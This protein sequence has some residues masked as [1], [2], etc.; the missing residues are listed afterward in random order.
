M[1]F[2]FSIDAI[3]SFVAV[4]LKSPDKFSP[5]RLIF[6]DLEILTPPDLLIYDFAN[7]R[8]DEYEYLDDSTT[9]HSNKTGKISAKQRKTLEA[10]KDW[11]NNGGTLRTD[12]EF[13]TLTAAQ[14]QAFFAEYYKRKANKPTDFGGSKVIEQWEKGNK[15]DISQYLVLTKNP[16]APAVFRNWR[17][18]GKRHHGIHNVFDANYKPVTPDDKKLF[19]L[20]QEFAFSMLKATCQTAKTILSIGTFE[21]Y[22]ESDI[23]YCNAQLRWSTPWRFKRPGI[24]LM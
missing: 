21:R 16:D 4:A 23:K 8:F 13:D 2:N 7:D 11:A 5:L 10:A 18:T 3:E 17:T 24:H 1:A 12:D 20:H 22:A 19:K 9:P 14:F 15:R 6:K